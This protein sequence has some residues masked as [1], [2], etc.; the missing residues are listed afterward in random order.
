[1]TPKETIDNMIATHPLIF[2]N[3]WDCA[4]HL[5]FT[6]GNG[7]VWKNGEIIDEL[8]TE[9]KI[10]SFEDAIKNFIEVENLLNDYPKIKDPAKWYKYEVC[11]IKKNI[12]T[13]VEHF[14]KSEK[15]KINIPNNAKLYL[16]NYDLI[17]HIPNNITKEWRNFCYNVLNSLFISNIDLG[18]FKEKLQEIYSYLIELKTK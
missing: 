13:I 6:C 18:E 2:K 7:Y 5:L 16:S 3:S 17:F 11:R 12:L 8:E 14:S 4:K 9:L 10:N 1:M 15:Y